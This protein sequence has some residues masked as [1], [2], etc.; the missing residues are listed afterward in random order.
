M[1]MHEMGRGVSHRTVLRLGAGLGAS[2]DRN[3]MTDGS[4]EMRVF[5]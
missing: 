4:I 2:V 1:E 3:H 5:S